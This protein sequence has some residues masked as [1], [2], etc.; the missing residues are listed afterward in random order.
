[1]YRLRGDARGAGITC[2]P[3]KI[4]VIDLY[5]A[6]YVSLFAKMDLIG[7]LREQIAVVLSSKQMIGILFPATD[8]ERDRTTV[9][10]MANLTKGCYIQ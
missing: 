5:I 7:Y 2:F 1:M 8:Q 4:E 10:L 6:T 3:Q 9:E